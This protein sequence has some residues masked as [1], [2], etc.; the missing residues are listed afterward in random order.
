MET[1]IVKVSGALVIDSDDK[2]EFFN[3]LEKLF[4][5]FVYLDDNFHLNVEESL[6]EMGI[7]CS[8]DLA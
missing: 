1:E 5:K 2:E 8:K 7:V 3:E 6:G 4:G